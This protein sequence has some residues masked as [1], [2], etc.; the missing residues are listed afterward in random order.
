MMKRI[1]LFFALAL[2]FVKAHAQRFDLSLSGG[3]VE[4][5]QT[6]EYFTYARFS[7]PGSSPAGMI[8]GKYIAKSGF[9]VGLSASLTKLWTRQGWSYTG[10]VTNISY[11]V[12]IYFGT[13]YNAD[14]LAGYTFRQRRYSLLASAFLGYVHNSNGSDESARQGFVHVEKTHGFDYG[15]ELEY[16][17]SITHKLGVG[18][19]LKPTFIRVHGAN[20]LDA[21]LFSLYSLFSLHYFIK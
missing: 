9:T 7:K 3:F 15:A 6:G 10:L 13:S 18:L 12:N 20:D 5:I 17:H 16:Q 14:V 1:V 21:S 19:L 2:G 11:P 4:T 8:S